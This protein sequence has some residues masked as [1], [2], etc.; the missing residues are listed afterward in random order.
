MKNATLG[1][2]AGWPD[3]STLTPPVARRDYRGNDDIFTVADLRLSHHVL[4]I[5]GNL[6]IPN[7]KDRVGSVTVARKASELRRL[8][9]DDAQ[10]DRVLV[11]RENALSSELVERAAQLTVPR[12]LICFMSEE[13]QLLD[14]FVEIVEADYPYAEVWPSCSNIGPVIMTDAHGSSTPTKD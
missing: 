12:G 11:G 9:S 1:Q 6:H 4:I 7:I 8:I 3:A 14:G 10:F 2:L 13:Q 5:G